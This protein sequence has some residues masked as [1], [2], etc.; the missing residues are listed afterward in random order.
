LCLSDLPYSGRA[1]SAAPRIFKPLCHAPSKQVYIDGA[2]YH[3]NPIKVIETERKLIW[4]NLCSDH[5]DILLSIGTAYNPR[6]RRS[7]TGSLQ[8]PRSGVI[9]HGKSLLKI[10]IDHIASSLD[11]EKTWE[12]YIMML[13][14]ASNNRSRYIR[15]NPAL[16]DDPPRLDD[17]SSLRHLKDV[18]RS[19]MIDDPQITR[20]ARRLVATSFYFEKT[21]PVK[22][23]IDGQQCQGTFSTFQTSSENN[24]TN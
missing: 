12:D 5:P 20:V 24:A 23:D 9:A 14:I 6:S 22:F 11:S 8:T 2:I 21:E 13:P 1:T 16:T 4:P 7:S 19:Q 18:V 10:A 17:V 3:N 15:V